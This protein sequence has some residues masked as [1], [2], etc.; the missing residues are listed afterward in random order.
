MTQQEQIT[1]PELH[2]NYP[3]KAKGILGAIL[4]HPLMGTMGNRCK[5][6]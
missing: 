1:I 2:K 4:I 6:I 5:N 3:Y